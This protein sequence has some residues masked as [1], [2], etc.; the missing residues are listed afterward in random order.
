MQHPKWTGKMAK[1]YPFTLDP[2][3]STSIACLVS[4][5]KTCYCQVGACQQF[6]SL[7][8]L[9]AGAT[10]CRLPTTLLCRL[11]S[12]A[13]V[14]IHVVPIPRILQ[15]EICCMCSNGSVSFWL[16]IYCLCTGAIRICAC[17]S[18]HLSR[19][20]CRCRVSGQHSCDSLC[21]FCS[22]SSQC[23]AKKQHV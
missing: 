4:Q 3:Q 10:A 20:D 1:E 14:R 16:N 7:L 19:Q 17:G 21:A 18:T 8:A 6:P 13:T 12:P 15:S 22:A 9:P 5:R 11:C 2:F 23:L